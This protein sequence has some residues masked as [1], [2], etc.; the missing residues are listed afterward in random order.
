M[1]FREHYGIV[2][3][4]NRK[5]RMKRGKMKFRKAKQDDKEEILALYQSLI[6]TPYCA[7]GNGYPGEQE[8]DYDMSRNALFCMENEDGEIIG[9]ITVDEDPQVEALTCWSKTLQPSA[10]LSRLGVRTDMQN[11]GIARQL[12]QHGMEEL[13]NREKR[14]CIFSCVKQ[15]KKHFALM[16]NCILT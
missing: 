5:R 8:F 1:H 3:K 6:G 2:E 9:T 4:E 14:V 16:K 10:E 11:Q 13:K 7:W 12:L 15:I